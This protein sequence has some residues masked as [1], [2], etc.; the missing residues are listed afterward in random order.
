MSWFNWIK[1]DNSM[2]IKEKHKWITYDAMVSC[3]QSQTAQ[4]KW[5]VILIE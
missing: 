4:Y 2:T 5:Q 3:E 1:A